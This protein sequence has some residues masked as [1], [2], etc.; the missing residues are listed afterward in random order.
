MIGIKVIPKYTDFALPN[1]H[2][3][4]QSGGKDAAYPFHNTIYISATDETTRSYDLQYGGSATF[5]GKPHGVLTNALI[6]GLQGE[7]DTNNDGV[8]TYEELHN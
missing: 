2:T 1:I 8:V 7:A 6:K 4:Q 3:T 5:D